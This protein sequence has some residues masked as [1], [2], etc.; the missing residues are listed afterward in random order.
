MNSEELKNLETAG[1]I[2]TE[3]LAQARKLAQP[4]VKLLGLAEELEALVEKH[5]EAVLAFPACLSLNEIAAHYTPLPKD[6]LA[7]SEKDVVKIDVGVAING[8]IADAAITIDFS[9]QNSKLVEA[10]EAALEAQIATVRSGARL[11]EL[12][13]AA[14][15]EIKKRGFKPVENLTGHLM[16][17]YELHAGL[18]VPCIETRDSARLEE[19][20]VLA[21]EPFASTGV[22]RVAEQRN[23]GIFRQEQDALTRNTDARIIQKYVREAYGPFYFAERWLSREYDAFKLALAL[24]ELVAREG[25][26][27]YPPLADKKGTLVSQAEKTVLVEKDGCKIITE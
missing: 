24:K 10:S 18:S 17:E 14:E 6:E 27:T 12:G 7:F 22:G 15:Q 3:V 5:D 4:G 21:L 1:K 8:F 13:K 2:A 26:S 16:E 11:G 9:G 19:G 20:M 25:F 23:V